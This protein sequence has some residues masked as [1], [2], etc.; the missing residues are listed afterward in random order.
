MTK[1]NQ[2][3]NLRPVLIT[4]QHRGVFAGLIPVNQDINARSM[5]L[6][7]AKMAI[8]WGTTKGLMELCESGPTSRSRISAPAD[9]PALHDIT[10]VFDITPAAWQKWQEA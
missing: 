4:T 3:D 5:A 6:K 2:P 8:Y 1:Q 7:S 10:A 9:I